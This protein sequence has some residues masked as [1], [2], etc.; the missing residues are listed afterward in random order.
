VGIAVHI[1]VSQ[2]PS[3]FGI[4]KAGGDLVTQAQSITRNFSTINPFTT[5]IGAGVLA[6]VLLARSTS[7]HALPAH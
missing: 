7:A 3:F 6:A 4:P 1:T 2:L 5:A